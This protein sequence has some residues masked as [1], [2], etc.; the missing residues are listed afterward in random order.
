MLL[1]SILLLLTLAFSAGSQEKPS[2]ANVEKR[3]DAFLGKLT[4][5]EKITLI[6]GINDF[7]TQAIPRLGIPQFRMS[8]GPMGVHDFGPTT[9]TAYPAGILLAA[10]WD[11]DLA[12]AKHHWTA[13]PGVF[14]IIVGSS[15]VDIRLQGKYS[16][17][18]GEEHR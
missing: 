7:Y 4:L 1:L 9:A 8:D 10:S 15:S 5:E 2:P 6:G 13:A 14:A 16:L 17:D 3:V 18:F 12:H 11:E